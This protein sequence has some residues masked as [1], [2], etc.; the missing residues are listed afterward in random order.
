[1][2]NHFV[3]VLCKCFRGADDVP[4]SRAID[5]LDVVDAGN[6]R[7]GMHDRDVPKPHVRFE[8]TLA[9]SQRRDD[10]LWKANRQLLEGRTGDASRPPMQIA[11]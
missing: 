11:P 2:A 4:G 10:Q 7:D 1:M 9:R 8:L 6:V 3:L 5:L